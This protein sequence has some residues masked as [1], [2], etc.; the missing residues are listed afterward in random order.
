MQIDAIHVDIR[1]TAALQ[2]AVPSLLDVDVGFLVQRADGGGGYLAAPQGLSNVLHPAHR[3][4]GQ[5]HLNESFLDA[6]LTAAVPLSIM[7]VSNE[8]P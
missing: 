1:V 3:D 4:T 6:A 5:V 2:R 7:A 8:I